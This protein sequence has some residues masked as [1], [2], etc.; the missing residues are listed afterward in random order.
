MRGRCQRKQK[1]EIDEREGL[2]KVKVKGVGRVERRDN[3][4]EGDRTE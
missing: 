4:S 2:G 3:M 1:R